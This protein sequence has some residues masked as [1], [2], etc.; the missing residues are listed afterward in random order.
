MNTDFTDDTDD[1][2]D[3]LICVIGEICL[4]CVSQ[5]PIY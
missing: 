4:I 5:L 2:D 1:T 3:R